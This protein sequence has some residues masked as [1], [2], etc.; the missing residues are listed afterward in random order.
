MNRSLT[1]TARENSV[2]GDGTEPEVFGTAVAGVLEAAIGAVGARFGNVQ[3]FDARS[4]GLEIVVQH[5]F[6]NEFL[7]LFAR[8]TP[9][10]PSTSA[11][12]RAFR[13]GRR[14]VVSDVAADPEF[15]PYLA[16]AR[17]CGFRAVQS[18]PVVLDGRVVGMLSTHFAEVTELAPESGAVLDRYAAALARLMEVHG[19]VGG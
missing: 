5:G 12:A 16:M 10:G 15:A 3:I 7:E 11:C 19:R 14:V 17:Q 2:Q 4:G 8:V 1:Q 9:A 18:T 13:A 6:P